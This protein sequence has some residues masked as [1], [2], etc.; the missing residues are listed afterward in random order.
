LHTLVYEKE[1]LV[2]KQRRVAAGL[3]ATVALVAGLVVAGRERS[4]QQAS[5]EHSSQPASEPRAEQQ[6]QPTRTSAADPIA[7]PL[8]RQIAA[9]ATPMVVNIRT[10]SRRQ[11][12]S[13]SPGPGDSDLFERF[14]GIPRDRFQPREQITEAAGS[15]FIVDDQGLILTNNHVVANATKITVALATDEGQE[16]AAKVIGR[17][18]L[19][20]SAL[21]QLV[22]KPSAKLP[23]ARLGKS[24]DVRP[25]DWVMAIGNPFNLAHTVTVGVISATGRPFPLSEGRSEDV[26]QTD[27]AINP[28][29]SGGPLLDLRGEVI[30]INTAILSGGPM[31][32][33]VGVGFAVPIDTVRE[34]IPELRRGTVTRGRIGVLVSAVTKEMAKPLG[35]PE[36]KGAL[37]RSVE[38]DGPAAAAG[39]R[40]GDVIV[41]FNGTAIE[42]SDELSHLVSR[43]KP[44]SKVAI[45]VLRDGKQQSLNVTV[46]QL[47]AEGQQSQSGSQGAPEQRFGIA[48]QD[49][50]ADLMTQ[51]GLPSGRNGALITAVEPGTPAARAGIHPGDVILEV[52]RKPV[53]NASAAVEALRAI[54]EGETGFLLL[55]RDRQEQFVPIP[56]K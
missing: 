1:F 20:D 7:A 46:G 39:V 47:D 32:G 28:G 38:R 4:S 49:V 53:A 50:P 21:I 9:A 23:V 6:A 16:Y 29:N 30:G 43:T 5:D 31:G 37:V 54:P 2:E 25:G 27:A 45:E 40:P 3:L 36:A 34:L 42:K 10:E 33:N 17:D 55:W 51:L 41:G 52:N 18:P 26:L 44:G 15:G 14:F 24:A 12:R 48:L 22:E 56:R 11:T 8:F 13:L 35:L 19:T